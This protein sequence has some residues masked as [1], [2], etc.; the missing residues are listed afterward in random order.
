MIE[1]TGPSGSTAPSSPSLDDAVNQMMGDVAFEMPAAAEEAPSSP[2]PETTA[3]PASSEAAPA[4]DDAGAPPAEDALQ[5]VDAEDPDDYLKDAQ[6]LDYTVDGQQRTSDF[7]TRLGKDGGAFVTAENL[8]KLQ[9]RLSERDHLYERNQAQYREAQQLQQNLS[10]LEQATAWTFRNRDNQ[11]VTVTGTDA[12]MIRDAEYGK[13]MAVATTLGQMLRED[14]DLTNLLVQT[15]DGRVVFSQQAVAELKRQSSLGEKEAI[16]NTRAKYAD[17]INR[18]AEAAKPEPLT[19]A[20]KTELAPQA[21]DIAAQSLKITGLTEE[22]RAT[23]ALLAPRFIRPATA[24]ELKRD[25]NHL[26]VVDEA[27]G[28]VVQRIFD[29]QAKSSQAAASAAEV[30]KQNAARLAAAAG[31][32]PVSPKPAAPVRQPTPEQNRSKDAEDAWDIAERAAVAGYRA[33]QG[34]RTA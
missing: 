28:P 9:Q 16:L 25:P 13:A 8:P 26:N 34:K 5:P 24:E 18:P 12:L 4:T 1:N 10:R 17:M 30:T 33:Q 29:A 3:D 6:P 23:L 21:V 20:Q 15:S 14:Q 27:F 2:S 7:I 22:S 19:D 32:R 31:R 11:P